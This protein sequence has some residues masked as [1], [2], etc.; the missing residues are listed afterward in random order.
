MEEVPEGQLFPWLTRFC[1][2]R[3]RCISEVRQKLRSKGF[4]GESA[5]DLIQ[6]LQEQDY[7]NEERYAILFAGGHFRQKQWGR[8]KIEA[9]LRSKGIDR[10]LIVQ[11]LN[12]LSIT[13]YSK[14]LLQLAEKA[15]RKQSGHPDPVRWARVRAMLQRK[16]Y[17]PGLIA[18]IRQQVVPI[19]K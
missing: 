1:A 4:V 16:G 9:A 19:K 7:L 17:E 14:T 13:A 2:Y 8:K 12:E 10:A 18:G 5:T 11:A 15:W 6:R 3:E